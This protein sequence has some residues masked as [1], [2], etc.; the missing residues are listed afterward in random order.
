MPYIEPT[1]RKLLEPAIKRLLNTLCDNR[2]TEGD[3]NYVIT[4]ILWTMYPD[5]GYDIMNTGL[6]IIEAGPRIVFRALP[7]EVLSSRNGSCLPCNRSCGPAG[8]GREQRS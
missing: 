5:I 8:S 1:R 2:S 3:V 7:T 4:R 6:G